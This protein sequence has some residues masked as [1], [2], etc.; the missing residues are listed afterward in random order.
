[1]FPQEMVSTMFSNIKSIYKFHH[2]FL[3]PVLEARMA[4]WEKEKRIGMP[5]T[6]IVE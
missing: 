6:Y 1:M 2:E 3:L 5:V 4:D